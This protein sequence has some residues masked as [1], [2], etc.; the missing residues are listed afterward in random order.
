MRFRRS[1]WTQ[2]N[3]PSNSSHGSQRPYNK[4]SPFIFIVY[5]YRSKILLLH[6]VQPFPILVR[7]KSLC[8]MGLQK[9]KLSLFL[10]EIHDYHTKGKNPDWAFPI[11]FAITLMRVTQSI[12]TWAEMRMTLSRDFIH[13]VTWPDRPCWFLLC[14]SSLI[15]LCIYSHIPSR[16]C[17]DFHNKTLQI[18]N[19]N[20]SLHQ[21]RLRLS[22]LMG[23]CLF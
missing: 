20:Q 6:K 21:W 5:Q 14:P 12:Q 23:T 8:I 16:S 17:Y 7:Q 19:G 3:L 13:H 11:N 18:L 10:S 1:L 15:T 4:S 22:S 9:N 2:S